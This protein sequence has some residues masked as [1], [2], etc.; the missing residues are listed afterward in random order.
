MTR[1]RRHLIGTHFADV[2]VDLMDGDPGGGRGRR[3]LEASPWA[4]RCGK[5]A[6]NGH[7]NLEERDRH[8]DR[9]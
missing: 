5:A 6:A 4:H 9:Q 8:S 7:G 3:R 2:V 1:T